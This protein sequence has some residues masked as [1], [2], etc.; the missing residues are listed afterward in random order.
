MTPN[1]DDVVD[2]IIHSLKNKYVIV[3]LVIA[4]IVG[5]GVLTDALT[6]II[7]FIKRL[8]RSAKKPHNGQTIKV[9]Q[10]A[11]VGAI[12]QVVQ[13]TITPETIALAKELGVT[14]AALQNF[15][16]ILQEGNVKPEDYDHT[17]RTI[18][19]RYLNNLKQLSA[20]Q[21][22]DPA[23]KAF[24]QQAERALEQGQFDEV[25]K[26]INDAKNTDLE[27]AK[28]LQETAH[29]RLFAAA[30]AAAQNGN[31]QM[32]QIHYLKAAGYFQEAASLIPDTFSK[33]LADYL[34]A[35]GCALYEAGKYEQAEPL[36]SR[37]LA[38]YEKALGKDHPNTKIVRDN[39]QILQA[40]LKEQRQGTE[41]SKP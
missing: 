20:L 28:T 36:Y 16:K 23:V 11:T 4:A 31:I 3:S 2:Q 1:T 17:L 19:E 41:K 40:R 25:E 35:E 34:N 14:Q 18:A 29:K 38:I 37:S 5:L 15:F 30:T 27:A 39:L 12:I 33:E 32:T 10:D 9:G 8:F 6:K 22:N 7:D 13:Q 26:L 24:L 21:A